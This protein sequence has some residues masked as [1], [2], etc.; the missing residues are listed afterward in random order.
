MK[1]KKYLPLF[2]MAGICSVAQADNSPDV[3][4]ANNMDNRTF[5][6]G[7]KIRIVKDGGETIEAVVELSDDNI[8]IVRIPKDEKAYFHGNWLAEYKIEHFRNEGAVLTLGQCMKLSLLMGASILAIRAGIPVFYSSRYG[9]PA[10]HVMR[11][12]IKLISAW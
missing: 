12:I 6:A 7:D 1:H 4:S 3:V 2:L 8:G 11:A 5:F 9:L 10:T